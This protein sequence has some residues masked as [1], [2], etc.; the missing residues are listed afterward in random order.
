MFVATATFDLYVKCGETEKAR[1]VFDSGLECY[2]WRICLQWAYARGSGTTILCNTGRGNEAIHAEGMRY[3][4]GNEAIQAEGIAEGMRP[5]C[6]KVVGAL[7]A[8]TRLGALDL[9]RQA[10]GMVHASASASQ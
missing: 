5:D 4:R 1:T 8:C 3:C 6:Y 7:S 9:G 10:V 2:G